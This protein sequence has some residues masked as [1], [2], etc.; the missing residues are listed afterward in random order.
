MAKAKTR[1]GKGKNEKPQHPGTYP[2]PKVPPDEVH[3]TPEE[4]TGL[5]VSFTRRDD[6]PYRLLVRRAD[7]ALVRPGQK[8]EEQLEGPPPDPSLGR[9]EKERKALVSARKS[10]FRERRRQAKRKWVTPVYYSRPIDITAML[11]AWGDKYLDNEIFFLSRWVQTNLAPML[12]HHHEVKLL[13]NRSFK[14]TIDDLTDMALPAHSRAFDYGI[15]GGRDLIVW[16]TSEAMLGT[17]NL[18]EFRGR[19]PTIYE[20]G[21]FFQSVV[22]RTEMRFDEGNPEALKVSVPAIREDIEF[23]WV[24]NKRHYYFQGR[25]LPPYQAAINALPVD[26]YT[27][28]QRDAT[29][30]W[31]SFWPTTLLRVDEDHVNYVRKSLRYL[32]DWDAVR[33]DDSLWHAFRAFWPGSPAMHEMD[34]LRKH[35]ATTP[36]E[37]GPD[38]FIN[39]FVATVDG[40]PA[41]NGSSFLGFEL[42]RRSNGKQGDDE[43]FELVRTGKLVT[44]NRADFMH[45]LLIGKGQRGKTF[46]GD[47]FGGAQETPVEW[48]IFMTT[49]GREA[50]TRWVVEHGGPPPEDIDKPDLNSAKEQIE[51][52]LEDLQEAIRVEEDNAKLWWETGY[53]IGVTPNLIRPTKQ[54]TRYHAYWL[55][56]IKRR[57][58]LWEH[59]AVPPNVSSAPRAGMLDWEKGKPGYRWLDTGKLW[60]PLAV[61]KIQDLGG[62]QNPTESLTLGKI[63]VRVAYEIRDYLTQAPENLHKSRVYLVVT[64]HSVPEVEDFKPGFASAFPLGM[65]FRTTFPTGKRTIPFRYVIA[66]NPAKPEE[67][68]WLI[69]TKVESTSLLEKYGR[70]V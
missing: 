34:P 39:G 63:T 70:Q 44:I 68:Y 14:S 48:D 12:D 45:W 13:G 51:A 25:V 64:A 59:W 30:A 22:K 15:H 35:R 37:P 7:S 19:V 21:S 38:E 61:L 62:A 18:S 11:T 43:E 66:F 16:G 23:L 54:S 5:S 36:V 53:P 2:P 42:V 46:Y 67:E 60:Q 4:I 28:L 65:H 6:M 27:H 10:W 9:S 58:E 8:Y 3:M 33:G 32:G 31:R 41:L 1:R 50:A 47:L 49:A 55:A 20:A 17:M 52:M 24:G 29:G 57:V 56:R 40:A 26:I 69:D